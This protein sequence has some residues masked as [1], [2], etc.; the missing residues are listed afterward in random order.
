M[1]QTT[2]TG[3]TT[4]TEMSQTDAWMRQ[5]VGG[6]VTGTLVMSTLG[7]LK[8]GLTRLG[9]T[10]AADPAPAPLHLLGPPVPLI[11]GGNGIT[12]LRWWLSS[13]PEEGDGFVG[14][15]ERSTGE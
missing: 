1:V 15:W 12:L 10:D 8:I 4:H 2:G 9:P 6:A 14:Y 5:A 7:F 13:S 11:H 3:R